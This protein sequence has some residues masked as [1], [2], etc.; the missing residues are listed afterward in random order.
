V[1]KR[2]GFTLVE[3]LVVIAIIALLMGILLP[4]LQRAREQAKKIVCANGL[5]QIFI[6]VNI[7][8]ND[9]GGRL[10]LKGSANW[11]WDISYS[12]TD[13]LIKVN[14]D[15]DM[16]A[17]FYCPSTPAKNWKKAIYWQ[18]QQPA[19]APPV[20][21]NAKSEDVV[22]PK[23]N[24]DQGFR[25]TGYAFV[26]DSQAGY[27]YPPR[28]TPGTPSKKWLRTTGEK[29][30]SAAEFIVDAVLSTTPNVSTASFDS[31][32][33]GIYARCQIYDISNHL[34]GRRPEG[35]NVL[36]LDGHTQWRNFS[37]MQVR[38]CNCNGCTIPTAAG[39]Q[40]YFWW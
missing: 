8:A 7:F 20:S 6:G 5:K 28:S 13:F 36:F 10:P 26:I 18:F 3:L 30:P 38:W 34:K 25:V 9:N 37:E 31:V 19:P 12:T 35:G 14:A 27:P 24:R 11:P 15:K 17:A 1:D 23:T 40:P 21:C 4:A 29:Q 22:E 33:G 39:S 16:K 32:D 2:R